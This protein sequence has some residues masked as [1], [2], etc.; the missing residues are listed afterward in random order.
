MFLGGRIANSAKLQKMQHEKKGID[1]YKLNQ[2]L[3]SKMGSK[4]HI[5]MQIDT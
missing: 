2:H 4:A 3:I 5:I 1:F